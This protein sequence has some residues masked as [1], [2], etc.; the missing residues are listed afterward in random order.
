MRHIMLSNDLSQRVPLF[1]QDEFGDLGHTFNLMTIELEKAYDQIKQYA[2]QA[3]IARKQERKVRNVFQRYVPLEV[4]APDQLV[5][6]LN[7]YFTRMVD[8]VYD[9]N[10]IVDKYIGD[11]VMAFF[12]APASA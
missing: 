3:V 4:L 10:G 8:L 12:G 2:Y 11:A 5:A 1:Y 9:H 7:D 6:S